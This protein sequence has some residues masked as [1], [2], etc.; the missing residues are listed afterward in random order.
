MLRLRDLSL[1]FLGHISNCMCITCVNARATFVIAHATC[2]LLV[3]FLVC[4]LIRSDC[5][6]SNVSLVDLLH[7]QLPVCTWRNYV[8]KQKL[9]EQN[10]CLCKSEVCKGRL[11]S[12]FAF[13]YLQTKPTHKTWYILVS[14]SLYL[15]STSCKDAPSL[16][17]KNVA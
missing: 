1:M 7:V 6:T 15:V 5:C 3:F 12:Q 10:C 17:T 9:Q 16:R 8:H 2:R 4:I 11:N 13:I 14:I